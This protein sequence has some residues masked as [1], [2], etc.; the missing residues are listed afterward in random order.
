[1]HDIVTNRW[2]IYR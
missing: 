1:M 2:S